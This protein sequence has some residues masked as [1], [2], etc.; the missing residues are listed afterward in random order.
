MNATR[1]A[2]LIPIPKISVSR[3]YQPGGSL[4]NILKPM[5]IMSGVIGGML[6]WGMIGLMIGP[7]LLAVSWKL[8]A[9]WVNEANYQPGIITKELS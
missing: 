8:L 3:S 9:S 7:V 6:T 4:D 5:L 2:T 1:R